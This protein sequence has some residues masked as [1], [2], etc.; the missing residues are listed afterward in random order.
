MRHISA[1][2]PSVFVPLVLAAALGIA[3]AAAAVQRGPGRGGMMHDADHQA[4]MRGFHEL[5]DQRANIVRTVMLRPDGIQTV[6]ESAVPAVADLI[7][8]HVEAMVARVEEERPIHQRDPLF[9]E[10]FR[11]A[12]QIDVRYER[13]ARG[14]RVV[15]TSSDPYVAKLI[16]AHAS[17]VSAFLANG[18]AEMMKDHPVPAAPAAP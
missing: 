6:T 2:R 12:R 4:D 11:H 1:M 17:V 14:V 3:A 7:Y 15:E 9:R 10:I 18:H 5:L 8:T 16:Q 13:T